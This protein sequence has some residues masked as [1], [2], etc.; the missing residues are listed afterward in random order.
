MTIRFCFF[1]GE[2]YNRDSWKGQITCSE[3]GAIFQPPIVVKEAQI[4]LEEAEAN[5]N[6]IPLT[7]KKAIQAQKRKMISSQV[8]KK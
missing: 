2:G 4:T 7:D 3:C 1:C 5:F 8:R 6:K